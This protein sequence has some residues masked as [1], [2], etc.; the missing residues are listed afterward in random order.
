VAVENARLIDAEQRRAEEFR[1]I[2][3]VGQR[4]A[5]ILPVEQLLGEIAGVLRE[6]LGYYLVGIALIEGDELVFKAGAG[7]VWEVDGFQP[8]RLKVGEEGITGWVAKTGEPSLVPDVTKEPRYYSL[9]EAGEIRSELAVPLKT[10]EAV[11][12]VLHVQSD[13]QNA[14]D[15][16][17]LVVLQSLAHQAAMAIENARLFEAERRRQQEATLLAEMARLITST[18]NLDEVLRLTAQYAI[19][20]FRIDCCCVFLLDEES[21]TLRPAVQ[22]GLEVA[23]GAG[24]PEQAFTPSEKLQR[25][26]FEE[27]APLIIDDVPG[28][29][30]LFPEDVLGI[31]SALVVPLE[32]GGRRIGLIQLATNRPEQRHFSV[33]EAELAQAMANQAAVAIDNARLF[34]AEQR[35]AEQFRVI[36]EVGRHVTSILSVEEILEQIVRS[37]NMTLGYHQVGIGLVEGA[38]VVYRTGVGAFWEQLEYK[39]IRVAL[40]QEGISGLVTKTGEPVLVPDVSK[41]PRYYPV[42][43]DTKTRSEFVL[44][45]KTKDAVIGVLA[46]SSERLDG[47]DETDLTVLQS[48]AHQAALAL[49]NARLFE[50]E[51]LRAE[52]FRVISAVG[53]RITSILEIDELLN[54][55]TW[56][57]KKAFDYHGV[58]IGLV[59]GDELVF[60][61]GAG[62]FWEDPE[63]ETLS[64]KVGEEGITGWVAANGEPL[65][66]A[67]V[68]QE[69]RYYHPP[70]PQAEKTRSELAVPMKAKGEVIGVLDV[71]GDQVDAFDES[72]LVVIQSLA[73]QA[74]IAI[75]N[76]RLFDAE[77]RRA[78]QFRVITEVGRRITSILDIDEV[79]VEVV[80]LIQQAFDYDHVHIGLIEGDYVVYKHGAGELWEDPDFVFQPNKL[81]VGEEGFTGW[82]AGTGEPLLVPDVRE[83]PRYV[84]MVGSR[85]LSELTVPIRFK[86]KV[87]GVLNVQSERANAFDEG[88]L[89]VL[90]SLANQAAVAIDNA[91]LFEAEQRRAEQFRVISEV[92]RQTTSVMTVDELLTEMAAV[93][94]R[95][96]DYYH[97]GIGLI[98]DDVVVSMAEVGASAAAYKAA[99]LKVGQEGI[100]G[101]VA[102]TGEP[103]LVPDVS[104]DPRFHFVPGASDVRSH[105]CVPLKT[106]GAVIG[107]LSAESDQLDAFDDSDLVVLQS[108]AHQAAFAVENARF[109]QDITRQVRDLRALA[110]ASRI[111]SS[112]LDQDQLLEA[113]YEQVTRIAPT[114]FYAI[115][116]YDEETNVL[117]IE[118]NVDE[119]VRYPRER[120]VLDRGLLKTIIHD[121]QTLR[122]DSL[123]E[124]KH[125]MGVEPVP[126]GSPRLNHGWLGVPMMY[127]EKVVGAIVVG[128]YQRG[129]FDERHEQTLTSIANQAAVALEN[130]RLYQ[131]AQQV[132]VLEERQRLARDLHDAV[133][134]TL[135]SGSLIAEALPVVWEA[136]QEEGRQLLSEL[137]QLSRGALAEM[138]TLLLELRPAAL[139][140]ANLGDLLR[141][142]AEAM[143]GRTGLP[144]SV[145][146]E[147]RCMLPA[148]V[149]V[150]LYRIAQEALNNVV[151][152]AMASR[153]DV[154][155]RCIA[156]P[157]DDIGEKLKR[158][159]LLV[160][161]DGRGFDPSR[162][163]PDHMGLRIIRER[164]HTVGGA[165][166]IDSRPGNGTRVMVVWE[167][168]GESAPPEDAG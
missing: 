41:E 105:V 14:F 159:E 43:G 36:G 49:E 91:R 45:L 84:W 112:V 31:Q 118:I 162:V 123:T 109:F 80:R 86:D 107:V 115:A 6:T 56:L 63:F 131:Q 111:I 154:T 77:Q 78:E 114:D 44:P 156:V 34:N 18:L 23:P 146:V 119:G 141:Q 113:L 26:V 17:D 66:V 145:A 52:Q 73:N 155:L 29:P 120:Y 46:V 61:A 27:L 60:K 94:Q 76:A 15:E 101:W 32:T 30:H 75:D 93:I 100:W 85:T 116:L 74:A 133:T 149:H 71:E 106:K 12:G 65:L 20:V 5:S 72:D 166:E 62:S 59:E 4:I 139:V 90:Q 142:L 163:P 136:D 68:R 55:L 121:R 98:E 97:V 95:G 132:A 8:P 42:P 39:P 54:Q 110:D 138:R 50:A 164:A 128:S 135:F 126:A 58:G 9:P 129:A 124:A 37:V 25:T 165:A 33:H 57:I 134:Q 103:L 2:S 70:V 160:S 92:G 13:R 89:V 1:V 102:N 152:H 10:K 28:D 144:I 7:A 88:D 140:E 150:A 67:D 47:F 40:D 53:Q 11:I 96:L 22:I 87:I 167:D 157:S 158:V 143:I 147:G 117:S 125:K 137:R 99:R 151:K 148:E 104:L 16:H 21:E 81:K 130:A 51:Q 82:V 24:G 79:L 153:V 168:P 122:F 161:D 127:G 48:L 35:R 108:L 19:D 3:E 69:A 64:L 83:D 38:E